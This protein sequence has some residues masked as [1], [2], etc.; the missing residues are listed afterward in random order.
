MGQTRTP[1]RTP[2]VV[3]QETQACL[4]EEKE[5]PARSP[6][7]SPP[8][9]DSSSQWEESGDIRRLESTPPESDPVPQ[10]TWPPSLSTSPPRFW[11]W[12]VTPPETTRSPES[13][14]GTSSSPSETMRS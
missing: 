8:R 6:S 13:S 14:Q 4:E 11:S 1:L 3:K 9:L 5:S 7:P 10:S 12:P 2:H